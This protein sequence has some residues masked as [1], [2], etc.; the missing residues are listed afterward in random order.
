MASGAGGEMDQSGDEVSK[1][2]ESGRQKIDVG[3]NP[4]RTVVNGRE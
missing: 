2:G 4:Q 3:S 1:V